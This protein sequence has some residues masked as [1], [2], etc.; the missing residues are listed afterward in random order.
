MRKNFEG[1]SERVVA[2]W[3]GMRPADEFTNRAFRE[4]EESFQE[5]GPPSNRYY[6]STGAEG[7]KYW[8]QKKLKSL[9]AHP[10]LCAIAGGCVGALLAKFL[11]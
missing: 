4:A 6:V 2:W 5:F 1:L 10:L 3:T 9:A 7:A 11:L 8:L